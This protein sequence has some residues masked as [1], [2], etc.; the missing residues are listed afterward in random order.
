MAT[1]FQTFQA[2][3]KAD[4]LFLLPNAWDARSALMLQEKKFQAVATSSAA[5][6]NSLGYEDGEH[7]PF[8]EYL[9]VI[10]RI[11][12]SVK[13]P[14]TVDMEM[15]YGKN[16]HDILD[17][18]LILA[19]RGV[20]GINIEDSIFVSSK[21]TLQDTDLFSKRIAFLKNELELRNKKLF[22][23]VR[24][25]TYILNHE[26]KQEESLK[27]LGAYEDSGADGIFLPCIFNEADIRE[28]VNHTSLPINVMCFPGLPDFD[29]LNTLG[30]KRVSFGPFM[31]QKVYQGI[32]QL[33]QAITTSKSVS[34][35]LG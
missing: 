16:D 4:Q 14:L 1:S 21:R 19:D 30:V 17:N 2:L 23:N 22:I 28:A 24:C 26:K 7:M 12:S 13:V 29:V 27:R 3:H 11:L 25:D 8:N 31:F 35:I 18:L 20:A 15:G 9:F 32:G 5:V 6:A 33:S 34:P 10:D